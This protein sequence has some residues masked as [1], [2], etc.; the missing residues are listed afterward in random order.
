MLAMSADM[1]PIEAGQGG[2]S[3][4]TKRWV[5]ALLLFHLAAVL[6]PPLAADPASHLASTVY[7]CLH[8]YIQ[9]AYLDNSYRF[10]A[11][12]PSA[13]NLVRYELELKDGTHLGG[14]FPNLNE[15]WPRLLYH[16]HFMLS[17]RVGNGMPM[18]QD[19]RPGDPLPEIPRVPQAYINSYANHLLA[20]YDARKV[21]LYCRRHM[22]PS[23]VDIMRGRKL[24]DERFYFERNLGTYEP[25]QEPAREPGA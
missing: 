23:P 16:R 21:T 7:W 10:F 24:S 6:T 4:R 14:V 9:A 2:W 12:E 17:E 18:A 15:H 19:L 8:P 22:L 1:K 25:P 20:A 11:P 5:S 3:P 13:S